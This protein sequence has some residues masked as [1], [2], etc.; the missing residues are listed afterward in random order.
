MTNDEIQKI[1]NEVW[2]AGAVYIGPSIDSLARFVSLVATDAAKREELVKK[3]LRRCEVGS[4]AT[5]TAWEMDTQ[6]WNELFD[7]LTDKLMFAVRQN[8]HGIVMTGEECRQC[9]AAITKAE[10]WK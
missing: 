4:Y 9:R 1:A 7:V 8:E 5:S 6:L 10:A 3:A 2:A